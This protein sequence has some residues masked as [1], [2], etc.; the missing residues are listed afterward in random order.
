MASKAVVA[1]T[2][3][4]LSFNSLFFTMVSSTLLPMP[5][6][7]P[8][9]A[10]S[11]APSATT[12]CPIDALKLGVCANVLSGLLNITIGQP[13]KEPCCRLIDGLVD[14]EAAVCLCTAIK[15]NIFGINL[16]IPLALSLLLNNCG[17]DTPSG[18]QCP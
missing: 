14:L 18:F 5:S 12:K 6:P 9:S 17:K 10:P 1:S 13:P 8:V 4:L 2:A 7:P 15:A 11:P 3:L 16:D